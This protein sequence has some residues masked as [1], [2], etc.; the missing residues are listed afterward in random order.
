MTSRVHY[1]GAAPG[2]PAIPRTK[3]RIPGHT[4]SSGTGLAWRVW[5]QRISRGRGMIRKTTNPRP[6]WKLRVESRGLVW[7]DALPERG[8][9]PVRY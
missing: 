1:R 3:A 9:T 8:A 7:Y 4:R 2:R 6:D 5:K